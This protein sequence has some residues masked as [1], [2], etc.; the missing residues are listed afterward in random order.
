[1]PLRVKAGLKL[2]RSNL[3]VAE[4]YAKLARRSEV[5][6]A[7]CA[8]LKKSAMQHFGAYWM[9]AS[10]GSTLV[11]RICAAVQDPV[12]DRAEPSSPYDLEG[13]WPFPKHPD[14]VHTQLSQRRDFVPR[15]Y[16][17]SQT[18]EGSTSNG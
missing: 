3:I 6:G 15:L 7:T 11:P 12:R 14:S 9:L 1:M 13:T 5:W 16:C 4:E 17:D 8:L 18:A 10:G 2:Y